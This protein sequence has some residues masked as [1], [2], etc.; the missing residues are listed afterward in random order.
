M[1]CRR[2]KALNKNNPSIQI[3]CAQGVSGRRLKALQ[4]GFRYCRHFAASAAPPA[5]SYHY[6]Q[7]LLTATCATS[8]GVSVVLVATGNIFIDTAAHCC[9]G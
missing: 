7:L 6:I 9:A 1:F 8:I 3:L 4:S 5:P 2:K